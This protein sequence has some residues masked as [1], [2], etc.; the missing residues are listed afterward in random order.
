[1]NTWYVAIMIAVNYHGDI[2]GSLIT[3]CYHYMT[4][5]MVTIQTCHKFGP[6]AT[7]GLEYCVELGIIMKNVT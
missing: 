1:M 4:C 7:A 2:I 5:S 3:F 6:V